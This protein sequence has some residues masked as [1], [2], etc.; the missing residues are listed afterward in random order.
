LSGKEARLKT[1]FDSLKDCRRCDLWEGRTNI[2]F[3][4]G[5]P[6][7]RLVFVGE[8]PGYHEDLQAE[9]FVGSAGRFLDELLRDTVGIPREDVFIANVLKCRPPENR[10]PTS[11]EVSTCK[12]FLMQQLEIIEPDTVCSLGNFATRTLTGKKEGITKLKRKAVKVGCLYVFP[13]LHPA[14]ALHRGNLYDEV[15][16]DFRALKEFLDSPK[17]VDQEPSQTELF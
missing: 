16:Q 6:D 15:R 17:P 8:A 11:L 7:A 2:V 3:G 12:P 14:A 13:M 1:L 5:S 10:D 9:P 4:S